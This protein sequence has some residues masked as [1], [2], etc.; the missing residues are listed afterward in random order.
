MK[1]LISTTKNMPI[2]E[3]ITSQIRAAVVKG[4]LKAGEG[5]PSIRVLAKDLQVSVITTKRAYEELEKE[6]VIES[7]PGKGFYVC[8]QNNDYLR[9]K[10]MMELENKF[11]VLIKES[12]NAGMDLDDITELV[13]MLYEGE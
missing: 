5:L 12:K 3:Q 6:G 9:E 1:I 11:L 10:Q 7:V 8:H 13:R 2:Y 4:A